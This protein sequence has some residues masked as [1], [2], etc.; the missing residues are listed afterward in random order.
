MEFGVS[1]S[2]NLKSVIQMQHQQQLQQQQQ[3]SN[4]QQQEQNP[5]SHQKKMANIFSQF[6]LKNS[7]ILIFTILITSVLALIFTLA[8]RNA[9]N[10]LNPL[11]LF[12]HFC[13]FFMCPVIIICCNPNLKSYALTSILNIFNDFLIVRLFFR[14][15]NRIHPILG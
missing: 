10:L 6:S 7:L 1:N 8:F 3:L 4:Q 15:E 11:L 12:V 9:K 2:E 14:N 13:S 5:Q